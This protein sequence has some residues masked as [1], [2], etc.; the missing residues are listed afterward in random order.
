[1]KKPMSVESIDGWVADRSRR[2]APRQALGMPLKAVIGAV[3][4]ENVG[5]CAVR[6]TLHME[7][8]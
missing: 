7:G 8:S 5:R 6:A 2:P 4:K 1:M 3:G